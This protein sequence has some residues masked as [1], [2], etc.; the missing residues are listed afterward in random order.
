MKQYGYDN[1]IFEILETV[2]FSEKQELYDVEDM[3]TIK[4][5]SIKNGHNTRVNFKD[6]L[7]FITFFLE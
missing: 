3:Y 5:D 6:Q 1:F 2:I 7:Q 4:Y